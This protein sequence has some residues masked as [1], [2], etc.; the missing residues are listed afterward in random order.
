MTTF[1]LWNVQKNR[2]DGHIVRLVQQHKVDV[3]LLIEHPK[4]DDNLLSQLN[5]IG[6]FERVPSHERFGVFVRFDSRRLVRVAPPLPTDRADY[7][8][9]RLSKTNRLLLVLVHGLDII[10]Y[11]S[12]QTRGL[13]FERLSDN[14]LAVEAR[15]D[16]GHKNTV[17]AGDF[18]ANPF[19]EYCR[20]RARPSCDPRHAGRRETH[21]LRVE[22]GL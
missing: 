22:Q 15:A 3:L 19:S 10:N 21:P 8:D 6:P 12:E 17:V 18:N 5:R 7:W 11:P 13:F 2:L 4:P 20:R 14:I 1:L 9:V 16:V